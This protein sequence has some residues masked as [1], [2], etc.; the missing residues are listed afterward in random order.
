MMMIRPIQRSPFVWGVCSDMIPTGNRCTS[1]REWSK[2]T[3][4]LDLF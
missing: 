2:A 4:A 3:A 1:I